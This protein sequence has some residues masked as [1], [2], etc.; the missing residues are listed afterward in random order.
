MVRP[1]HRGLRDNFRGTIVLSA[2]PRLE[3]LAEPDEGGPSSSRAAALSRRQHPWTPPPTPGLRTAR[4]YRHTLCGQAQ[5][6]GHHLVGS[7]QAKT[8]V[9]PG[10][11]WV[12]GHPPG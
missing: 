8:L 12:Q 10:G 1:S 4:C 11:I 3:L 5:G 7:S 9:P 2:P 6:L